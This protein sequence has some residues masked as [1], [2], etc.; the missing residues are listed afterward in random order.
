MTLGRD[1]QAVAPQLLR[2]VDRQQHSVD[3]PAPIFA[4]AKS[5]DGPMRPLER[6][7]FD[8]SARA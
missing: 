6:P 4:Y 1:G 3:V 7:R 5:A 8:R 2:A